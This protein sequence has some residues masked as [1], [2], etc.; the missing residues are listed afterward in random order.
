MFFAASSTN[1]GA[2]KSFLPFCRLT[3]VRKRVFCRFV[4]RRRREKEFFAVS[5]TD[6]GPEKSFL[7]FRRPTKAEKGD[8][9][10]HHPG[11]REG[12]LF[13]LGIRGDS[14]FLRQSMDIESQVGE[15]EQEG[16]DQ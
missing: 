10:E 13:L 6:E 14:K 1:E 9:P 15:G 11:D 3:K 8:R 16:D 4:D 7:P 12:F 5:S 2:K